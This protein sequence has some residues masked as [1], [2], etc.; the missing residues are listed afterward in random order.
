MSL[1]FRCVVRSVV[2]CSA[3][4]V[5]FQNWQVAGSQVR[6]PAERQDSE[7]EV[8]EDYGEWPAWLPGAVGRDEITQNLLVGTDSRN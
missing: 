7:S 5:V 6:N 2:C 8:S 3:N 4:N 1:L